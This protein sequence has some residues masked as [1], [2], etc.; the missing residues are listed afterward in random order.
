LKVPKLKILLLKEPVLFKKIKNQK[1]K[2]KTPQHSLIQSLA[3]QSPRSSKSMVAS[4]VDINTNI[5]LALSTR[6]KKDFNHNS[7]CH[8]TF[9]FECHMFLWHLF[10]IQLYIST[11]LEYIEHK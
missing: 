3:S 5:L 7:T 8:L 9:D 2:K 10:C 1:E 6:G 11:Y 4:F